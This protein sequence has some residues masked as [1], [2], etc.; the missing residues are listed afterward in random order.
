VQYAIA[1]L[2]PLIPPAVESRGVAVIAGVEGEQHQVGI[3]L[4]SD[5]LE[6]DGWDVIFLGANTPT[7]A[8]LQTIETHRPALLGVS[9]TMLFNVPRLVQLVEKVRQADAGVRIVAGG[10]VFRAAPGLCQ[11]LG[12]D[13][14]A[15]D[16]QTAISLCRRF[17]NGR[18]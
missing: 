18:E 13:G 2:Y 17:S 11:E 5:A 6:A 9:V 3:N 12:M 16:V 14:S 4:I 1:Q 7:S 15:P 8:I 10:A